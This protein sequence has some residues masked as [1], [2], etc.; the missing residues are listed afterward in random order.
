VPKTLIWQD[1]ANIK[2]LV[3]ASGFIANPGAFISALIILNKGFDIV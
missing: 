3:K 2:T 1:F